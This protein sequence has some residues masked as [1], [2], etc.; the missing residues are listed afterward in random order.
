MNATTRS[1]R[2]SRRRARRALVQAVYQWQMTRTPV[3]E[4]E[5]DFAASGAL[6]KA[7]A[8]FFSEI[9][10]LAL[11]KTGELDAVIEPWLDRP[12]DKLDN[13]ERAV[14]RLATCEL[15]HRI[16]VPFR[17]V[18][19]EYVDLTKLFGAEEGHRFI[20]GVLDKVARSVRKSETD[21]G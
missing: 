10:R 7:D 4:L 17:V 19:D 11:L 3:A 21:A 15:L 5:D 8:A 1:N 18:I 16:D 6:D 13:V 20:N 2:W 12:L 9:L 14:L